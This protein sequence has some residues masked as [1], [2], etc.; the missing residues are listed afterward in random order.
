MFTDIARKN[1]L[2]TQ[3]HKDIKT[4]IDKIDKEKE[5]LICFYFKII[6]HF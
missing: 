6:K 4:E 5:V 1:R 2:N 3:M